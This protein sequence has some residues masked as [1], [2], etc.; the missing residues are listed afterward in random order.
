MGSKALKV[1]SAK[2][3]KTPHYLKTWTILSLFIY[4][5][6]YTHDLSEGERIFNKYTA[7]TNLVVFC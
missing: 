3:L 4:F 7:K 5:A 6:Q 2:C 1:K